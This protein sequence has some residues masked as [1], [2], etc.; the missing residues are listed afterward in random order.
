MAIQRGNSSSDQGTAPSTEGLD[1]I[2]EVI[3]PDVCSI[4]LE[5]VNL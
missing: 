4:I 3:G 1:E 2:F 5:I